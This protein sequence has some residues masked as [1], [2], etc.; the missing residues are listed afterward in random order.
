MGKEPSTCIKPSF[1]ESR[2]QID[3]E[4]V[5]APFVPYLLVLVIVATYALQIWTG[6]AVAGWTGDQS[7]IRRSK[8]PRQYW[9]VM[10]L[11]TLVLV[12]GTLLV[13]KS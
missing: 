5:I 4:P 13:V 6:V 11:Q 1:T 8:T 7:L 12:L 2:F 3:S 10:G 9:F